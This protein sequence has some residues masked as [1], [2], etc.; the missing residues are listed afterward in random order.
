MPMIK[1]NTITFLKTKWP[2][3]SILQKQT[4]PFCHY[5]INV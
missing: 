2:D 1:K 3:L 5:L 4:M